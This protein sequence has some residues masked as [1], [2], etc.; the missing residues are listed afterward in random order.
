MVI[1]RDVKHTDRFFI[2]LSFDEMSKIKIESMRTH[3]LMDDI[4]KDVLECGVQNYHY[5]KKEHA[6]L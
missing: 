2:M 3:R 1:V 4:V 5:T 6:A